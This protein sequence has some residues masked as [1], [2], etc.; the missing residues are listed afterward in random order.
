MRTVPIQYDGY[1]C[2]FKLA[3]NED[4]TTLED[5]G[6]YLVM[7]FSWGDLEPAEMEPSDIRVC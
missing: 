5:S 2:Q 3:N 4:A 1:N 6:A 7:D